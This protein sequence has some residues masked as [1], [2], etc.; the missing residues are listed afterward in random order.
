MISNEKTQK[1]LIH[2]Q[3]RTVLMFRS[4]FIYEFEKF[5]FKK[6]NIVCLIAILIVNLLSL[7]FALQSNKTADMTDIVFNSS[8]NFHITSLQ[9]M[10]L[11]AF[12]AIVIT[13][14]ILSFHEEYRKGYLRM[15]F[16]RGISIRKLYI[17][18]SLVMSLNILLTI[19]IHLIIS[20]LIALI[21]LPKTSTSP[22]YFKEGL[23][24]ISDVV[25]F[26][27]KYYFL[28]YFSLL[29]FGS[30]IEFLSIKS[31]SIAGVLG[32]SLGFVFLNFIYISYVSFLFKNY[33]VS[34][35]LVLKY[36]SLSFVFVQAKGVAYFASGITDVFLYSLIFMYLIF[37]SLS[38]LAFT[39]KNYLE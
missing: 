26:S 21:V 38:Y 29:T 24:G 1:S 18:K 25:F 16:M 4:L 2:L 27:I 22:L 33:P 31:R 8:L 36:N 6:I 12:N 37:K 32:L 5:W 13:F 30:I 28:A 20:L 11:T 34:D 35:P 7:K 14:C 3:Q 10:L 17:A 15:T 39:N 9:E 19:I 23:Y